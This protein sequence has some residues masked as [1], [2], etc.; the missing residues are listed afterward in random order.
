[1]LVHSSLEYFARSAPE[2]EFA[3]QGARVLSYGEAWALTDRAARRLVTMGFRPGER[4]AILSKNSIEYVLLYCAASLA[5]LVPVPLNYRLAPAELAFIVRDSESVAMFAAAEYAAAVDSIQPEAPE[6]RLCVTLE[7]LEAWAGASDAA[8]PDVTERDIAIQMYTSGTTGKPKGAMLTHRNLEAQIAQ[9][10]TG[11]AAPVGRCLL[12]APLY[13]IAAL[14]VGFTALRNGSSLFILDAFVPA[15]VV[16]VLDEERMSWALLVPAMIQ[17]CLVAAPDVAERQYRD[18]K[19]IGYGASPISEATLQ[20]AREV[21]RCDF[22]Q[23]YGMTETTACVTVLTPED[24]QRA[25]AGASHLL[26]SAGR[27]VIGTEVRVVDP[28]D[29][30]VGPGMLGEIVARGPQVMV[31]Y[32]KREEA[33]RDAIRNGWMHTGDIGRMDKDGY[34]YI[35]DRLKDMIVSGGE[36]VYPREVEDVLFSHDAVADVAVI[37]IPDEKWGESVKAFVVLRNGAAAS[38]EELIEYC[39]GRLAGYKRPQ[40]VDILEALPRNPSGKVLKRELRE[41]Y[42]HGRGRRVAG[43]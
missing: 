11:F 7:E 23:G 40:S 24:H 2:R 43:A 30:P 41:P 25:F 21:F 37:G 17:A 32:W 12:V 35:E 20:R 14:V 27:A 34:F 3:V 5:G 31:G 26:V 8:L 10:L 13:H 15:E 18:L 16:R 6:L 29:K 38:A 9:V 33:T 4:L 36:N 22:A 28:D 39:K 1:M 42:W 19:V